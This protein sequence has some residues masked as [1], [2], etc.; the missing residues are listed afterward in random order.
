M[1]S[2][3]RPI[4]DMLEGRNGLSSSM[5]MIA[6]NLITSQKKP[7]ESGIAQTT[8][9]NGALNP[10]CRETLPCA[11]D[12]SF[13]T[14]KN[15]GHKAGGFFVVRGYIRPHA[16]ATYI[17]TSLAAV[18][19]CALHPQTHLRRKII[20]AASSGVGAMSDCKLGGLSSIAWGMILTLG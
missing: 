20:S 12:A 19:E 17:V 15:T 3:V 7:V 13:E 8:P 10:E 9:A 14:L 1:F 6:V 18:N 4:T 16:T 11:L 2:A 5:D